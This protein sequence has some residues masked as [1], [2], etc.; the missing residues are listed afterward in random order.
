MYR[1]TIQYAVPDDPEAFDNRYTEGHV[2]LVARVPGLRS[3]TWSKVLPMGG[4]QTV[5][6]V[7]ELDFDDQAALVV[8]RDSPEMVEARAD[9]D[10]LGVPRVMFGGEV[11]GLLLDEEGVRG[12]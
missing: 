10:R 5:Y 8:A 6:L 1:M 7:A 3:Y 12:G 4:E 9:A 11:V 2:P